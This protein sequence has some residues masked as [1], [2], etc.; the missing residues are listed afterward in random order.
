MKFAHGDK[1]SELKII[2][3][4]NK[5]ETGTS[6]HFWPDEKYFDSPRFA[7]SKLKHTL[8]AKAVLCPGLHVTYHR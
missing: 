2:G 7:I 1:T 5:N 3:K 4:T 6:V 8:R